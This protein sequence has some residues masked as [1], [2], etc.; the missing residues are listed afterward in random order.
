MPD[1]K[2]RI[3]VV[4][5]GGSHGRAVVFGYVDEQPRHGQPVTIYDASMILSWSGPSGLFGLAA[6]GPES[7]TRITAVVSRVDDV[8]QQAL[9]VSES[10]A[11][12]L[13]AWPRV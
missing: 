2:Q 11:Q 3:P 6:R 5:C 13:A 12:A 8:C 7:G 4:I 1:V 9:S 10:A